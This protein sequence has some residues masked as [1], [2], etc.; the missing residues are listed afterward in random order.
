NSGGLF[1]YIGTGTITLA[2]SFTN[3]GTVQLW[4]GTP[5]SGQRPA[6]GSAAL[7]L[8]ASSQRTWSGAGSYTLVDIA[9]HEQTSSGLSATCYGCTGD[10]TN[11][12][13]WPT[14]STATSCSGAPTLITLI[15]LTA[16]EQD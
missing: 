4:G 14:T 10:G 8:T 6:C 7:T 2:G 16:T 5:S 12:G 15:S 13:I 9:A 3:N 1:N 11:F